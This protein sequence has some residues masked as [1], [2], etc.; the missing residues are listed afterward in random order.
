MS[1]FSSVIVFHNAKILPLADSLS[2]QVPG[3]AP[4]GSAKCFRPV[5]RLMSQMHDAIE[6]HG[7]QAP[8]GVP[9]GAALSRMPG[10][11]PAQAFRAAPTRQYHHKMASLQCVLQA[12]GESAATILHAAALNPACTQTSLRENSRSVVSCFS[13][14]RSERNCAQCSKLTDASL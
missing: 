9:V 1:S 3:N 11:L 7:Q 12:T 14:N 5:S 8:N 13:L 2:N 4:G 10:P 6:Q